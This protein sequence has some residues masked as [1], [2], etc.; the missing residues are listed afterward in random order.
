[1]SNELDKDAQVDVGRA[2]AEN[3]IY[4]WLKDRKGGAKLMGRFFDVSDDAG[5]REFAEW[6]TE[7]LFEVSDWLD[8]QES[9]P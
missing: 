3:D 9:G 2:N 5:K 7:T 1:V 6:L 8:E 4:D